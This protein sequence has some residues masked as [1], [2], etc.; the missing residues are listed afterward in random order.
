MTAVNGIDLLR[1]QVHE[2]ATARWWADV[3]VSGTG[4][5][6]LSGAATVEILDG[7]W[8][9][10][11]VSSAVNGDRVQARV[12]GGTNGLVSTVPHKQYL[13]STTVQRIVSDLM[14]ECGEVLDVNGSDA[15]ALAT[16]VPH[17]E[18]VS[19]RAGDALNALLS[20]TGTTWSMSRAGGVRVGRP[21]YA[22]AST[23]GPVL[24][25]DGS[26][27]ILICAADAIAAA[28]GTT[29]EGHAIDRVVWDLTGAQLRAELYYGG[30]APATTRALE[31]RATVTAGVN[32]QDAD[33]SLEVIAAGAYG[34]AGVPLYPGL[35][36]A[37]AL[38]QPGA[39]VLVAYASGDPRQPV[40]HSP[41]GEGGCKLGTLL[42]AQN[43]STMAL[44]PAQFFAAG[45]A[46][47]AA[48]AAAAAIVT[49]GGNV[50]QLVA[51]TTDT[52]EQQ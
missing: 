1:A 19:T 42:L 41:R 18:R 48:A 34:L 38:L 29:V 25:D 14:S 2:P 11:V 39:R 9:G 6:T 37:S 15:A 7:S 26:A 44:L 45:P 17:W 51:L 33:G 16:V 8:S 27:G 23:P 52:V 3:E 50:A 5:A 24:S 22:A 32:S 21:G 46:G 12:V 49:G 28:P 35:P 47:D 40:A 36:G 30:S 43:A 31:E 4:T 10:T 13:G 20:R